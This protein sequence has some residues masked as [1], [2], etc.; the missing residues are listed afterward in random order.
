MENQTM[1]E[2]MIVMQHRFNQQVHPDY[3]AQDYRWEIAIVREL[4]EVMDH[5]HWEW[6]K[7][8]RLPAD[9]NQAIMEIVDVWHFLLSRI[10]V[11]ACVPHM[12]T[13]SPDDMERRAAV[14]A[15]HILHYLPVDFLNGDA[16]TAR[17]FDMDGVMLCTWRMMHFVTGKGY[18]EISTPAIESFGHLCM[19]AGIPNIEAL[20]KLYVGKNALNRVRQNNGYKA[21]T[22]IKIWNGYEDNVYLQ[23]LLDRIS[24][25]DLSLDGLIED[26]QQEYEKIDEITGHL[27]L[28]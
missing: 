26:L 2:N 15:C 3:V 10:I 11:A 7:H 5:L 23:S 22:Y 6:W 8:T 21:G 28:L 4:S 27:S 17:T 20:Y 13:P 19:A 12:K 18:G 16:R 25:H 24:A 1:M 9:E 14:M